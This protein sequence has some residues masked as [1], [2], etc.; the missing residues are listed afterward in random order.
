MGFPVLVALQ[1]LKCLNHLPFTIQH[2]SKIFLHDSDTSPGALTKIIGKNADHVFSNF[3]TSP[4]PLFY[5]PSEFLPSRGEGA[6]EGQGHKPKILVFGGSQ[7]AQFL[8]NLIIQNLEPLTKKYHVT[9]VTGPNNTINHQPSTIHPESFKAVPFLPQDKLIQAIIEADLVICRSGASIFQVLA[10]HTKM[11]CIPLPSAARNHQLHNAQYFF[12]KGLC[13]LLAQ[14]HQTSKKLLPMMEQILADK[15]LE[16][17]LQNYAGL[18]Q[19]E[20]ITRTITQ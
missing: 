20:K 1:Y 4:T 12:D 14:N 19:V 18:P 3:G 9:L 13:Y 5:W 11:I 10:A 7:G 8:N 2:S 15:Q 16:K 6:G 17:K